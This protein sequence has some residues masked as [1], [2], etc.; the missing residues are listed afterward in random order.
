MPGLRVRISGVTIWMYTPDHNPPHVHVFADGLR[1][2]I[3]IRDGAVFKGRIRAGTYAKVRAWLKE[4]RDML[5][6]RWEELNQ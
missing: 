2:K 6:A 3:R 1:A 4:N 5:L